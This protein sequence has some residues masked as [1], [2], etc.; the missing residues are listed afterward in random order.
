MNEQLFVLVLVDKRQMIDSDSEFE[1]FMKFRKQRRRHDVEEMETESTSVR[2]DRKSEQ[3]NL[4]PMISR[5]MPPKEEME[6]VGTFKNMIP[7][8]HAVLYRCTLLYCHYRLMMPC[9]AKV[10]AYS[11]CGKSASHLVGFGSQSRHTKSI[12]GGLVTESDFAE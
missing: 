6:Q 8:H 5:Q 4:R 1:E 9:P 12:S 10:I 11:R 2:A 7:M 3:T